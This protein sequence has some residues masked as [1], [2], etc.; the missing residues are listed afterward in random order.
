MVVR[1]E[2]VVPAAVDAVDEMG[3][4]KL[5]EA[6]IPGFVVQLTGAFEQGLGGGAGFGVGPVQALAHHRCYTS[7]WEAYKALAAHYEWWMMLPHGEF[8]RLID[9]GDPVAVLLASHWI[10]LKLVMVRITETEKLGF[11]K[12]PEGMEGEKHGMDVGRWVRAS[13]IFLFIGVSNC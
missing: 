13:G 1:A 8:E 3:F 6:P 2:L 12:M 9:M 10:A 7:S 11:G 4:A 5:P